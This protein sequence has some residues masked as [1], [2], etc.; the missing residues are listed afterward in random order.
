[1]G[2]I[3]WLENLEEK[4]QFVTIFGKDPTQERVDKILQK[5]A[6]EFTELGECQREMLSAKKRVNEKRS[7]DR[8]I[9]KLFLTGYKDPVVSINHEIENLLETQVMGKKRAFWNAHD[10]AK[11]FGFTVM[12][13]IN[14]YIISF[15]EVASI[16]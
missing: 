7:T 11:K 14:A 1:M 2:L 10:L 15:E 9:K 6:T 16:V 12:G 4:S 5:L 8:Y 13:N 3:T